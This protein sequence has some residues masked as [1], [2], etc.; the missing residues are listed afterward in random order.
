[1]LHRDVIVIVDTKFQKRNM[2]AGVALYAIVRTDTQIVVKD[3]NPISP[4]R[5]WDADTYAGLF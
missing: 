2:K 1:M 4:K 5:G 3:S